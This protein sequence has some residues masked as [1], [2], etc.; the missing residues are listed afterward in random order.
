MPATHPPLLQSDDA[1]LF[2]RLGG[3]H[4][5]PWRSAP[6]AVVTHAHSDHATAGCGRYL[7]A[8]ECEPL[9]RRRVGRDAAIDP[10]KWGERVPIGG[11]TVS[12]HPAGHVRGSAQVRVESADEVWVVSG[13][14]KRAPD[15]TCTPF[16]P[17]KCDVFI[18]E[19]T[20]ALPIYRWEEPSGVAREIEG[21]WLG[22][23]ARGRASVLFC[24]ALGKA[25]RILSELERL[26]ALRDRVALLH[27]A[28]VSLVEDYRAAGVPMLGARP[29]GERARGVGFA[30]ELILAP[31]SAAG[32]PWM[33]RF[34]TGATPGGADTGFAS[35]WMRVRGVRRRR[36]Y[37]RG[38]V[39]SDH[40]DWPDLLRTIGQSGARLVLTT[41]GY[42][43]TLARF[44]RENGTESRALAT[45]FT[46]EAGAEA[47][48]EADPGDDAGRAA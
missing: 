35:G 11:V 30:G 26:P 48:A 7:C 12:V 29:V 4:V 5:D 37:D 28:M 33:R 6:L 31:P 27:G 46:G 40:A 1:G 3:F 18:T 41:H 20:F 14:Y 10:L 8:A 47:D 36:G 19:A 44:L 38:F 32:S 45:R 2:C 25:Q 13:D 34:E 9:L 22:N 43:E 16:E 39:V 17:V 15:P 23:A 21:W 42:A 24:Y